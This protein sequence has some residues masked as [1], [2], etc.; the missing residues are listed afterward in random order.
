[1]KYFT[2]ILKEFTG[3]TKLFVLVLLLTFTTISFLVSQYLQTDDCK[4]IIEEN[5]KM[6]EDFAKISSLLRNERLKD[7]KF[8]SDS[9]TQ[10]SNNAFIIEEIDILD[11]ILNISESNNK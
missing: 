8:N 11:S 5:L 7:E 6:H 9:I 1:M 10:E 4:P 2:N 3:T